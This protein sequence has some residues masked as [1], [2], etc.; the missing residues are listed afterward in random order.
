MVQ[1]ANGFGKRGVSAEK[2]APA[3]YV[4][5]ADKR[6]KD[7][8]PAFKNAMICLRRNETIQCAVRDVSATGC[9]VTLRNDENLPAEFDIILGPAQLRRKARVAWR[10]NLE[11]GL[12][13]LAGDHS[14]EH[15][16]LA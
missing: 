5:P 6:M 1:K 4:L 9:M 12:E 7:R 14:Q 15:P 8:Q 2:P 3:P 16:P 11:C 10:K 13:F